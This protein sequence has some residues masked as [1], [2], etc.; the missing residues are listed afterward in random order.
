MLPRQAVVHSQQPLPGRIA[1]GCMR[2]LDWRHSRE[3]L[4]LSQVCR[5]FLCTPGTDQCHLSEGL[6]TRRPPGG[7]GRGHK[8]ALSAGE[9]LSPHV[10]LNLLHF[11][12][13]H[14][15]K[16][17]FLLS[18]HTWRQLKQSRFANLSSYKLPGLFLGSFSISWL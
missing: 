2:P 8:R 18:F 10:D 16:Q 1:M 9:S 6:H 4:L 3:K 12:I 17:D 15:C 13:F 7:G 5:V 11:L 14:S